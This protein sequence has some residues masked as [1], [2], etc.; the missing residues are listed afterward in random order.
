M[1]EVD[2]VCSVRQGPDFS[3]FCQNATLGIALQLT[4]ES[5]PERRSAAGCK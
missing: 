1:S 5:N 2:R 3:T 4:A